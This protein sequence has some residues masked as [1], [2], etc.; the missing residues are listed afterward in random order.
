MSQITAKVSQSPFSSL[1]ENSR[2][3]AFR[4]KLERHIN[5]HVSGKG[6]NSKQMYQEVKKDSKENSELLKEA[7]PD[8]SN[9]YAAYSTLYTSY[10]SKARMSTQLNYAF[11]KIRDL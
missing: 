1:L 4:N 10:S 7:S 5:D 8:S 11:K 2:G 3:T 9:L 6:H